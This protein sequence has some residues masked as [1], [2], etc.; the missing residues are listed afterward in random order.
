[1]NVIHFGGFAPG[2]SGMYESI[3]DQI[4][5][6]RKAGLNSNFVDAIFPDG[7]GKKDGWLEAINWRKSLDT[8]I[9]VQHA[10]IPSPLRDY[11]Q[12]ST[13]NRKKH[14]VIT[15]LHGPVEHM[16]IQEWLKLVL[17]D[18]TEGS[19]TQ[20][21]INQ[22]WWSEACVVLNQHEY[23]ISILYDENNKLHY[24]PN[25]IDLER[26]GDIPDWNYKHRPAIVSC[27]TPRTEKLPA[28]I[29]WAMPTLI[30]KIPDARLNIYGLPLLNIEFFRHLMCRSKG[31]L[32]STGVCENIQMQT[33]NMQCFLKGAD[34]GFNNN[35]SGIASRVTMEMMAMGIPVVSYNGD[36]TKYHA[37][38]FDLNSIAEQVEL[39][40]NDL[41][42]TNLKQ[43]TIEYAHKN[44]NR[45]TYI[46]QYIKL[47]EK[48][49][50]EKNG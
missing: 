42:N 27:D 50:E 36:Y 14:V 41:Q 47:Y 24:I 5:Y 35:Y 17:G 1:M 46:P 44:F 26:I 32:L 12:K 43:E 33:P 2:E 39:C 18:L 23:D 30:K 34:I 45:E 19:F 8:E 28:H 29:L 13:E 48:L 4:K 20:T 10:I 25:S 31:R 3:K 21:H 38:I 9:W 11:L 40:W 37:R 15:I 7:E 49:Q 16:L 6:E 22:I